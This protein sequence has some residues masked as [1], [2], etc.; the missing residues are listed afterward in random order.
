MWP[1]LPIQQHCAEHLEGEFALGLD[2]FVLIQLG[3]AFEEE[4]PAGGDSL[5]HLGV[6]RAGR[7]QSIFIMGLLQAA[8]APAR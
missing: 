7:N 4:A 6:H 5:P 1:E 2:G 3:D 8:T